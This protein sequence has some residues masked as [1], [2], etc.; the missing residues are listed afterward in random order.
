MGAGETRL[1]LKI[2]GDRC[3]AETQERVIQTVK[4]GHARPENRGGGGNLRGGEPRGLHTTEW[5]F[6]PAAQQQLVCVV[7]EKQLWMTPRPLLHTDV[8]GQW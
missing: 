5:K 2:S 3:S 7:W 1:V 8:A 6:F 4:S